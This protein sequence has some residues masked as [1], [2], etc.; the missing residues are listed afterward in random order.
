MKDLILIVEDEVSMAKQLKWG[1]SETYDIE[2]AEHAA[3]AMA[4]LESRNPLVVLLDLGL[5][6]IRT[7]RRKG[8]ACSRR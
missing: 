1:L 3:G 8:C 6:P 7:A 5:P 4:V 2:V